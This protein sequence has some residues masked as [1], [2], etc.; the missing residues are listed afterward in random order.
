MQS[1]VHDVQTKM[2][3]N[4][5]IYVKVDLIQINNP[6][7]LKISFLNIMIHPET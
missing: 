1:R 7:N 5:F 4:E 6:K 3:I 2:L